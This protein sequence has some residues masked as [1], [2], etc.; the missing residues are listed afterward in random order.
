VETVIPDRTLKAIGSFRPDLIALLVDVTRD[1]NAGVRN[2]AVRALGLLGE[3][4][5]P[6]LPRLFEVLYTPSIWG[7]S[8]ERSLLDAFLAIG[9]QSRP[10]L[11]KALA[12]G[13]PLTQA[14][15][16]RALEAL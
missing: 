14:L 13:S 11:I 2:S 12:N 9:K 15:A 4:A 7:A 10:G 5:V 6:A 1:E 8:G 3:E 16:M